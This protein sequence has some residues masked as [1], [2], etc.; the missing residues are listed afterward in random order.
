[1]TQEMN[2]KLNALLNSIKASLEDIKHEGRKARELKKAVRES[3]A[4]V[5]EVLEQ[6]LGGVSLED[7]ICISEI[8]DED[9]LITAKHIISELNDPFVPRNQYEIYF[10]QLCNYLRTTNTETLLNNLKFSLTKLMQEN[11]NDYDKLNE[12]YTKYPFWGTY[13]E[14]ECDYSTFEQRLAVVK[15]HSYDLLWFYRK[16]GDYMSKRTLAGI[17]MN[18]ID[19]QI[20]GIAAVKSIF[21]DYCEPDIFP[22]NKGDI[23]VDV[24]AYI[25]DSLEDYSQVYGKD[26]NKIYIYEPASEIYDDLAQTVAKL[27]LHDVD[28]R[29][30]GVGSK[31]KSM[32]FRENFYEYSASFLADDGEEADKVEVVRLDD[33]FK[34]EP[35]LIKINVCGMEKDV[36]EGCKKLV[37]KNRPKLVVSMQYDY[38]DIWK[39]PSIIDEMV[40]EGYRFFVRS[41]GE[42]VVPTKFALLCL[43]EKTV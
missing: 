40:P 29:R 11:F 34:D 30:K 23:Y 10:A 13:D 31:K 4:V 18:W 3:R 24:G 27:G 26:Y 43:P 42:S 14:D 28:I 16:L 17:L 33:D 6:Q 5:T 36:L 25:G 32:Y 38:D 2:R 21:K 8:P 22:D 20:G 9:W 19:M 7:Q 37:R 39:I 35:T 15:Q 1:M 41:Y 12:I